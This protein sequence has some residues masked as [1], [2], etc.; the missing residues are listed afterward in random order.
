VQS[1][2]FGRMHKSGPRAPT[3]MRAH[4][5]AVAGSP[6]PEYACSGRAGSKLRGSGAEGP[7]MHAARAGRAEIGGAH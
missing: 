6:G 3:Q 4:T 7:G 2:K 1:G 5:G